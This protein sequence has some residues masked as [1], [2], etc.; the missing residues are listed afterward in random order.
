MDKVSAERHH[1]VRIW[2]SNMMGILLS[3]V[4]AGGGRIEPIVSTAWTSMTLV[5]GGCW[6]TKGE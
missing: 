3:W 1:G 5:V 4:G 6:D 2:I